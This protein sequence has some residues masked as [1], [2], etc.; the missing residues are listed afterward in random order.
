MMFFGCNLSNLNSLKCISMSNQG[1]NK[2]PDIVN[3]NSD[4]P[5]FSLYSVKVLNLMSRT[6]STR[7][8]RLPKTCKCKCRLYASI[9]NNRQ[10]C[11]KDKCRCECIEL[12]DKGSC[13]KE[14]IWNS[15]SCE[16]E[17]DKSLDVGE[18]LVYESCKCRKKLVDK[19]F[20]ECTENM[21]L[22]KLAKITLVEH[23][24]KYVQKYV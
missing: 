10:C 23:E 6:N 4:E 17:C 3:I 19:L 2:K 8:I 12:I 1:C 24:N 13:D 15:S 11:N 16:C 18:Y 5:T 7:Y 9:C 22:V 21:D 14:F 20:E